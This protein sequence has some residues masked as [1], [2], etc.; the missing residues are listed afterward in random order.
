MNHSHKIEPARTT[1]EADNPIRTILEDVDCTERATAKNEMMRNAKSIPR[2]HP[3]A[4]LQQVWLQ[5]WAT[6]RNGVAQQCIM[7]KK[8]AAAPSLSVLTESDDIE[9]WF[10]WVANVRGDS[11]IAIKLH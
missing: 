5:A 9:G 8:L 10:K 7:H 3:G 4:A 6:N 1:H 2:H 11:L